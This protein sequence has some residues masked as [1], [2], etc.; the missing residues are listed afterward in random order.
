M[1]PPNPK[2]QAGID[3][4]GLWETWPASAEQSYR[5]GFHHGAEATAWASGGGVQSDRLK[6]WVDGP[7]KN[8]RTENP[9]TPHR[10]PQ[11][12][13][14]PARPVKA[15]GEAERP[16]FIRH[17]LES[18]MFMFDYGAAEWQ[19][20]ESCRE[21]MP[22]FAEM[23]PDDFYLVV[24]LAVAMKLLRRRNK[25]MDGRLVAGLNLVSTAIWPSDDLPEPAEKK[26]R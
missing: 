7:L 5:R 15:Q 19:P 21:G 4:P 13:A 3:G 1:K 9:M 2:W 18:L 8:W 24:E 12:P 25:I 26:G 20:V 23:A 6:E 11:P 22:P 10:P 14:P 17:W 16:A